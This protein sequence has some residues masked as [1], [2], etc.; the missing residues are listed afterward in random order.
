MIFCFKVCFGNLPAL[1][2]VNFACFMSLFR[3]GPEAGSLFIYLLHVRGRVL[4]NYSLL[5]VND[6]L[7]YLRTRLKLRCHC[8][9]S[10]QSTQ[11]FST[12]SIIYALTTAI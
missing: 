5:S 1:F 7:F 9:F 10:V 8:W 6:L 11:Y 2:G 3:S 12:N 4:A